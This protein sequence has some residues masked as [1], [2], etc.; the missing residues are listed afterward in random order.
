MRALR[1]IL[2][3]GVSRL[4]PLL[5]IFMVLTL[6]SVSAEVSLR[7]NRDIRPILSDHCY[8]C[9][10]PDAH[11]RKAKLRFDQR[12][13]ALSSNPESPAIVPG[14]SGIS[15][16]IQRIFSA[17]KEE[18]MPPPEINKSLTAAEKKI[19]V[20]W[21]DEGALYE[22]HWAFE[23][24]K[25]VPLPIVE[26]SDWVRN[27]IDHFILSLQERKDFSPSVMADRETLIRRVT[28]DLTGLPPTL[29]E[30]DGFLEDD[31]GGAY[32]RVVDRLMGTTSYAERRAQ[33]WLDLARYADTR[34]FAD[35][36]MRNIWPWRDWVVRA[37][38]QNQPFDQFTIEQL[39]GDMLP[40][41]TDE[42]RL[43]TAFHRN[44]P[45]A[46]GQTYPVEE[47]RIK[48]VIDRVNTIGRVWLGLTLD[49]AECHDHKFDPITQYDY[50]SLLSIFNNIVKF[51]IGFYYVTFCLF[52]SSLN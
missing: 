32:E 45:Q 13:S 17:D 43:A 48:G 8:S 10:G 22:K 44:A 3:Q 47:Y 15:Q 2:I 24:P 16:M 38:D 52:F 21:I 12:D 50:Y 23:P 33:D 9:H 36:K 11:S 31:G 41:A 35:D 14:K 42:Q 5:P 40:E 1:I 39:A 46:R 6:D 30:I 25:R 26:K 49:C 51:L 20:R 34:G 4:C 7:F 28:L 18:V 29:E 19:L 37:L 27:P